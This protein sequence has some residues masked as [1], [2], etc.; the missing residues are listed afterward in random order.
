VDLD[1]VRAVLTVAAFVCFIGIV[2]W[3]YSRKRRERFKEAANLPFA[4]DA[5]K[6]SK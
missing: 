2:W 6:D 3:A 4:D 1:L 5:S